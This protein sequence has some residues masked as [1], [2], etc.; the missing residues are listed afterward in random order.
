M[1]T[2]MTKAE[3]IRAIADETGQSQDAVDKTIAALTGQIIQAAT[4]GVDVTLAGFGTFKRKE[5]S[6]RKGRNPATGETIDIAASSSLGFKQAQAA[7][8]ALNS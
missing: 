5:S 3:L 7:K 4:N 8:D 6:A 2:K 1:A